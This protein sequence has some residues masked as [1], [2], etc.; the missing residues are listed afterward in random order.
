MMS[1]VLCC[2]CVL[3]ACVALCGV[4]SGCAEYV[5]VNGASYK[6][7]T[8]DQRRELIYRARLTL[9]KNS[10]I[11]PTSDYLFATSHEPEIKISYS[12]DRFGTA[13]VTWQLPKRQYT[14]VFDGFLGTD[15][16]TCILQVMDKQ[17]D[18]IDFTGR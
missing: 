18:L 10:K 17:P 15:R 11:V 1:R 12:G 14:L 4:F 3:V 6:A 2:L 16:M 13:K 8:K 5:E 7:I 9:Y